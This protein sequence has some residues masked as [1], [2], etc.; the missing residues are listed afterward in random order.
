M[1]DE[2]DG[3]IAWYDGRNGG[4]TAETVKYAKKIGKVVHNIYGEN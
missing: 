2:A 3:V 1:V 4:G